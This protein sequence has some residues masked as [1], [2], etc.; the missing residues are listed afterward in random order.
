MSVSMTQTSDYVKFNY[1]D[2]PWY[3]H[4]KVFIGLREKL[5]DVLASLHQLLV[6][7]IITAQQES[8]G[9]KWGGR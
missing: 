8:K 2:T 4:S 6:K 1:H 7:F 9:D 5:K 3:V